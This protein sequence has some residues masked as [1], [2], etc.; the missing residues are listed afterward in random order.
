MDLGERASRFKFLLRDR[1]SKFSTAFDEAFLGNGTRVIKTP[2]RSPRA[3]SC[4][5]GELLHGDPCL[6]SEQPGDR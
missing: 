5:D 2:V 3:G 6:V 4:H 1:D